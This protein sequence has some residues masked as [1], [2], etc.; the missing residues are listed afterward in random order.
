[1]FGCH[2]QPLVFYSEAVQ[3]GEASASRPVP[4]QLH[5]K[6][7]GWQLC[8][9]ILGCTAVPCVC[10][11]LGGHGKPCLQHSCTCGKG[12]Q[13]SGGEAVVLFRIILY[14]FIYIYINFIKYM[15]TYIYIYI[16]IIYIYIYE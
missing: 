5:G 1:M 11:K 10:R 2:L 12:V 6:G 15:I 4:L 3:E 13:T 8:T 9:L 7:L 14:L 16:N